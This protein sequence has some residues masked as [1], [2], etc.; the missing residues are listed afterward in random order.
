MSKKGA[1]SMKEILNSAVKISDI[2]VEINTSSKEAAHFVEDV[3]NQIEGI[4]LASLEQSNGIEQSTK[5][6]AQIDSVT[7]Q[8]AAAAEETSAAAEELNAQAEAMM[9]IVNELNFLVSEKK[10]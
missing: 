10:V 8:N 9:G 3:R 6:V 5:A 7:Q 4:T 2:I 1:N